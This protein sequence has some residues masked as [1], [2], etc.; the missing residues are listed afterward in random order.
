M[1]IADSY[2]PSRMWGNRKQR[3]EEGKEKWEEKCICSEMEVWDQT[4]QR[5]SCCPL[6]AALSESWAGF[7]LSSPAGEW[8][9]GESGSTQ[10]RRGSQ[11]R[12]PQKERRSDPAGW[13]RT[14]TSLFCTWSPLGPTAQWL[15][16]VFT[17]S[18]RS[19]REVSA[20]SALTPQQSV[21]IIWLIF[22]TSNSL[23]EGRISESINTCV[24]PCGFS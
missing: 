5:T 16:L 6:P 12:C 20:C 9:A 22:V 7:T 17:A 2:F 15:R 18:L 24:A 19:L 8:A 11:V 4:R 14:S 10:G 1:D 13:G 21:S 23:P 3:K